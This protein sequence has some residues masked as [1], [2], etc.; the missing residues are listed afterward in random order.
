MTGRGGTGGV[1]AGR[2]LVVP[3]D[4]DMRC[5]CGSSYAA[6]LDGGQCEVYRCRCRRFTPPVGDR[7]R[8]AFAVIWWAR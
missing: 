6:H 7:I 1:L 4:R 8:A 2:F 3:S 5:L